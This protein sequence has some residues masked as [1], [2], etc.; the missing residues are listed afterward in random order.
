MNDYT[1]TGTNQIARNFTELAVES[2]FSDELILD[3]LKG[4]RTLLKTSI[5]VFLEGVG[6]KN[7]FISEDEMKEYLEY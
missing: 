1:H 2:N 7:G 4:N 6:L 5:I 3:T